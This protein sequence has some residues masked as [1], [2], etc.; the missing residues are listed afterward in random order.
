MSN[1]ITRYNNP[2]YYDN[3]FAD[4]GINRDALPENAIFATHDGEEIYATVMPYNSTPEEKIFSMLDDVDIAIVAEVGRS[5]Y[6]TSLQ[7]YQYIVLRGFHIKRAG[8]RN[9]LN[10]LMKCRMLREYEM[11]SSDVVRGIRFYELDFRGFQLALKSDVA[12]HMGNRFL[13]NRKKGELGFVECPEDVKRILTGNMIVLGLL[14]NNA[15]INEFHIMETERPIQEMPITDGS[16]IRTAASVKIDEDV[17]LYEVVRT[18]PHSMRKL[19]DKVSRYYTLLQ[20]KS[21]LKNNVHGYSS[22][23]QL[24]ICAE[25]LEH[26]RKIDTYLRERGLWREEDTILYTHDLLH[27]RHSLRTLYELNEDGT[28]CWYSMPSKFSVETASA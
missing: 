13:S 9:R 27:L 4:M 12:F 22:L 25:S 14:M 15:N 16:I 7:I 24:V 20:N 28:L 3:A 6:L 2:M 23:P 26:A 5:K 8:I 1:T 10:K 11:K 19:A 18:S 21:Y 17:I